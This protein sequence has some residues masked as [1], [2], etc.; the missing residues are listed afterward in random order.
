[1]QRFLVMTTGV[2]KVFGNDTSEFNDTIDQIE[3]ISLK[4]R[5]VDPIYRAPVE[6]L[7]WTPV[8]SLNTLHLGHVLF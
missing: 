6:R 7:C 4:N 3:E 5:P 2:H 1:V 8:S